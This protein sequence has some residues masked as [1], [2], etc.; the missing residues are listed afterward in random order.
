MGELA[1]ELSARAHDVTV[2]TCWPGY[3]L[4]AGTDGSAYAPVA[5]ENGAT[6]IRVKTLPMHK[7]NFIV[8]GLATL[9]APLQFWRT[10][11]RYQKER[12]DAVLVYA[13]P[14][15]LSF[16]AEWAKKAGARYV[17]NVQDI[18]PQN[19]ID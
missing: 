11:K 7:V 4:E 3:K 18:F 10:L 8:R 19:A 17:L 5:R 12:F 16:V 1:A 15:T 13:P 14:I 2:L 6:V 9:L